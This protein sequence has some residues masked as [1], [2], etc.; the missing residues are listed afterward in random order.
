MTDTEINEAIAEA[1][2]YDFD[3]PEAHLW[4]SR[5][6][7]VKSPKGDILFRTSVPKF[8]EDLNKMHEAITHH[9]ISNASESERFYE[10]FCENLALVMGFRLGN[11]LTFC[12][13]GLIANA[14]AR[15]R[16]EAF[17]RTIGKWRSA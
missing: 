11:M 4:P 8:C 9:A 7:R 6:N 16:S 5:G 15:Q 17:L 12:D 13:A 14:T 1:V 2:G 3:P 10:A